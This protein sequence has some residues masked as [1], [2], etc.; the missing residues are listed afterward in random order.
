[1][2]FIIGLRESFVS[3]EF[4]VAL[5]LPAMQLELANLEAIS[6]IFVSHKT[7]AELVAGQAGLNVLGLFIAHDDWH[8]TFYPSGYGHQLLGFMMDRA[9]ELAVPYVMQLPIDGGEAL[10]AASVWLANRFPHDAL[11][12]KTLPKRRTNAAQHNPR[13]I[14][15]NWKEACKAV[16]S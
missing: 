15:R 10:W 2:G 16:L 8:E 1:L 11:P 9:R 12:S 6:R 13:R 14:A 4:D 5:P 3:P 7:A